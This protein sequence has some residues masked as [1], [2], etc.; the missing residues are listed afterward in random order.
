LQKKKTFSLLVTPFILNSFA[1]EENLVCSEGK[2]LVYRTISDKYACVYPSTAEK[3]HTTGFSEPV[4]QV[5]SFEMSPIHAEK[6]RTSAP[7]PEAA[8]GPQ[9]DFS[10]GY[11]VEE[12]KDGLYWVTDGA[13]Q[14]MFLTTGQGVIAIDAPP[15]IGENY[16]K[17]IA[18]VTD[19]PITHIIYSHTHND[20]VGS[21]SMFPDDVIY[22]G[23]Q[24]TANTLAKRNDPNR[25]VPTVTFEDKYTLEVGNQKLELEYRG[26]MHEPGN[27]LA[28]AQDTP[29]FLAAH[30][31]ILEY[32][33]DTYIGGHLTRLGTVEDVEIQK[34]Y[35]QDIQNS[36]AKAN[37]QVSFMAIGQEVGFS[38]PWLVFQIYADQITQQCADEVVPK[39]VDRLGGVDLFTYDHCWKISEGQRI[40]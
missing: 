8:I 26:P 13:Y 1:E 38:N 15:S 37:Q 2:V 5:K 40:D 7:L 24:D 9:I 14:T 16:L 23:H 3:W 39:W 11:L 10:K 28:M 34:E 33:F 35:F 30:D 31:K 29:A 27:I 18:E 22:I 25:P 4:Q 6:M 20:H 32:D 19:E 36:A 21:M 12:I 17:A